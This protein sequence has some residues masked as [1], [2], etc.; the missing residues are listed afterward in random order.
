MALEDDGRAKLA[1]T[2]Y[3]FALDPI[4]M[5]P[6]MPL[7]LIFNA[8]KGRQRARQKTL[9]SMTTSWKDDMQQVRRRT[10][11]LETRYTLSLK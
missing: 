6:L 7:T 4:I 5:A 10:S 3:L 11:E 1:T 2:Q 8:R 9:T